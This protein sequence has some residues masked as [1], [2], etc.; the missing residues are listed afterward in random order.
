MILLWLILIPLI[1]GGV[2]WAAARWSASATRW[3]ALVAVVADF[4]LTLSLW[5]RN[6]HAG[7]S[8][9][10]EQADWAWI[11]QFG[12]RL[13][14]ALDGLSLLL[15]M[16]T[17]FLG[18]VSV[19]ASWNEITEAVGFFHLNLLWILAGIAGVFLAVNLF[20]FYFAWE[21]MLVP[22]YFLISIW[23]HENRV[24]AAV[25]FF[26][27]TQLS[28]LLMLIAILALFFLHYRATGIYTFEY[29][30]LLN[31]VMPASTEMWIMLGFFV[32]FA[33]KLP[34][35]VLH[36]W[37]PDAH[38]EAPTAG[39]VILA[40][41]LLKTGAYGMLRFVV[42]LFPHAARAFAP[43]AMA[44]GVAGILYGAIL[45][46]GQNDLKRLVAYTSVSHLGFVL[47]GIF[48]WN[49]LAL[50][51]AVMTMICHGISTG[52]L[53]ILAGALQDRI[54]TREMDCMGGLW[55]TA[56]RL[57]GAAL[58]F[59]LA[60]LGL[61]GLG[62][63]VGEF[64]V[65]LGTYRQSILLAALATVGVLFA[66]FYALRLVQ[67]AFQGPNTH[68]WR[69]ADLVPREG[70]VVALMIGTLLWLGLYPRPVLQTFQP[71]MAR[72][73]QLASRR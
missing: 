59:A 38:T 53:F 49:D 41:L 18:I 16:L 29:A 42:P 2:A 64:L 26:L 46:F 68:N 27:F 1:A 19:L 39:S 8:G 17:F 63:F 58:F 40:G 47:L 33:V 4:A 25:K 60:S 12:I 21:L 35:V 72:L 65:L 52:G 22:M 20:L 44:L 24:Y 66:T 9:W 43:I 37:L 34:V 61:P 32:A 67:R 14:L 55:S 3:I 30:A 70:L 23:G 50:Q 62:D 6:F 56:P 13:H 71:V 48:A 54:H 45:A 73:E 15:L 57:S 5:F 51:G 36:T 28:G 31:T 69:I 10:F 11:P 7:F